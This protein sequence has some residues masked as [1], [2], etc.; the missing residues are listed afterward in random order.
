[1]ARASWTNQ[2]WLLAFQKTQP[3]PEAGRLAFEVAKAASESSPWEN[4]VVK[5][6]Y[7][8]YLLEGRPVLTEQQLLAC[9]NQALARDL[10]FSFV[11]TH[12]PSFL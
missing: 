8:N 6:D 12:A 5:A 9:V 2:E 1:M 10:P 11:L 7:Y 3:T 4:G